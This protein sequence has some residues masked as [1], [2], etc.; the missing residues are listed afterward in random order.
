MGALHRGHLALVD[1][2]RKQ[3][4]RVV[5]TIFV[6][7]TQFAPHEDFDAYPR[8]LDDDL[9]LCRAAG[10]DLVFTPSVHDMYPPGAATTVHVAGLTDGLCGPFRPGHFDGVATV[11]AKLF[12]ILPAN[13]ACFGEKDY[14][15]LQVIRRMVAD[16]NIP[17]A[18][19]GCPTVREPDGLA[20][21]SRNAYL[22]P[23][24]RVRAAAIPRALFTAVQ[25]VRHGERSAEVIVREVQRDILSAGPA[26]IEYVTVVDAED[27]TVITRFD[28]PARLCAAVRI[29]RTRLIDNV[30]VDAPPQPP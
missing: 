21:S 25:R 20:L 23:R 26:T 13:L 3:C 17:T 24:E 19:V 1:I 10:I 4:D 22:D 7:P 14:Q 12:H 30:P 16:L 8:P 11:V 29:G 9:A 6:N 15:Q 18:I 28:R 2:A 5:L 27:L